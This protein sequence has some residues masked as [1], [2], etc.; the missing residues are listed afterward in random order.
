MTGRVFKPIKTI[1]NINLSYDSLL[2]I[3]EYFEYILNHQNNFT[4]TLFTNACNYLKG[5]KI[6]I[7]IFTYF[8]RVLFLKPM[9]SEVMK[10]YSAKSL[11]IDPTKK[12]KR[13]LSR[14]LE[15]IEGHLEPIDIDSN[16]VVL[17][18]K[19]ETSINMGNCFYSDDE[20]H[21]SP[22]EG[23]TVMQSL[24]KTRLPTYFNMSSSLHESDGH[25]K[26][27]SIKYMGFLIEISEYRSFSNLYSHD[28]IIT[29]LN[30]NGTLAVKEN[31]LI[32][33]K[34]EECFS[35]FMVGYN[36]RK[37]LG[38]SIFRKN[39][40]HFLERLGKILFYNYYLAFKLET[41]LTMHSDRFADLLSYFSQ[42]SVN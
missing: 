19:H 17:N 22:D 25:S 16:A 33:E 3:K 29:I 30:E 39:T 15:G 21:P 24:F 23:L 20:N 32:S 37:K 4:A 42:L 9:T 2:N 41:C 38:E 36:T 40:K 1:K 26:Q 11:D 31:E 5:Q 34:Y 35:F 8:S 6:E 7:P 14:S 28:K 12:A 18:C 13:K 27:A 10:I